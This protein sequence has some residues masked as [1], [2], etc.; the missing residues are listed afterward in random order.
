M[1]E[2]D[3]ATQHVVKLLLPLGPIVVRRMYGG[4]ALDLD[5]RN[6]AIIHGGSVYFRTHGATVARYLEVGSTALRITRDGGIEAVMPYHQVPSHVLA[7][8]DLACAWAY[9]SVIHGPSE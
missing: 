5:D 8:Q 9:E 2:R 4:I 6:F 7:D 3:A 1:L